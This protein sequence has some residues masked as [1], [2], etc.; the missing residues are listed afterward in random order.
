M[1]QKVKI[2]PL[3]TARITTWTI[4]PT[5]DCGKTDFHE[6]SPQRQEGW[7][8]AASEDS[9]K[10]PAGSKSLNQDKEEGKHG[11]DSGQ[12][13]FQRGAEWNSV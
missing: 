11:M 13:I 8:T 4:P 9:R 3:P 2:L 12:Y 7:G 1:V 5:P 6:T 10:I